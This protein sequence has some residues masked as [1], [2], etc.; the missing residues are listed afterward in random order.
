MSL[1]RVDNQVDSLTLSIYYNKTFPVY[2]FFLPIGKTFRQNCN[3]VNANTSLKNPTSFLSYVIHYRVPV[4]CLHLYLERDCIF[5]LYNNDTFISGLNIIKALL[6]W[7]PANIL[8]NHVRSTAS[9]S[10]HLCVEDLHK[11]GHLSQEDLY[12]ALKER[13][14]YYFLYILR[15]LVN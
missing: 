9:E 7:P 3:I 4:I 5:W 15:I 6:P 1:W 11:A 2:I 12:K 8:S 13:G 14:S 10:D